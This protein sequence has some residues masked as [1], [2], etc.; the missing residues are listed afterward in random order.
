ME[1]RMAKEEGRKVRKGRPAKIGGRPA[2]KE[3]IL[4]LGDG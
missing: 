1:G 3:G 4:I 2:K